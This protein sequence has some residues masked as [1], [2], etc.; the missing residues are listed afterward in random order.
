MDL[1]LALSPAQLS[2]L[3]GETAT[4]KVASLFE[5]RQVS[6]RLAQIRLAKAVKLL[7]KEDSSH[8]L[9][10]LLFSLSHLPSD[11]NK[12]RISIL[13]H[14]LIPLL[15]CNTLD[16]NTKAIHANE[17]NPS[18]IP[19]S[20]TEHLNDND[21]PLHAVSLNTPIP[22]FHWS[23]FPHIISALED[24]RPLANLNR[25]LHP[26]F[27]RSN[28]DETT[29]ASGTL[30]TW[31]LVDI[32]Q[33]AMDLHWMVVLGTWYLYTGQI[34]VWLRRVLN[35]MLERPLVGRSNA[36]YQTSTPVKQPSRRLTPTILDMETFL[37]S[38]IALNYTKC[39][40]SCGDKSLAQVLWT[41]VCRKAWTPTVKMAAFWNAMLRDYSDSMVDQVV[42][43]SIMSAG[44]VTKYLRDIRAVSTN[45]TT[46][47]A[48]PEN[49][50][51]VLAHVGTVYARLA[52]MGV[53]N[54]TAVAVAVLEHVV[55]LSE[56]RLGLVLHAETGG[57]FEDLADG[58]TLTDL[59]STLLSTC[60]SYHST[61]RA[62]LP[63]T[64]TT[65]PL[66]RFQTTPSKPTTTTFLPSPPRQ[67]F[68]TPSISR[69][70]TPS[71][72][73]SIA[74]K[75]FFTPAAVSTP[76]PKSTGASTTPGSR[77][78]WGTPGTRPLLRD[79]SF[80]RA[81]GDLDVAVVPSGEGEEEGLPPMIGLEEMG[82]MM[83]SVEML[84]DVRSPAKRRG[85]GAVIGG[86]K[87]GGVYALEG[88]RI[89]SGGG[90]FGS[91][92]GG[93]MDVPLPSRGEWKDLWEEE[94]VERED[95]WA[96]FGDGE[97]GGVGGE[98]VED[99]E[100]GD[101][102]GGGEVGRE[103]KG[104]LLQKIGYI[105]Y[106]F[107]PTPKSTTQPKSSAPGVSILR[108]LKGVDAN[109][110]DNLRSSFELNYP[111]FEIL[112]SVAE[113]TDPAVGVVRDLMAEFPGVEA[114][115]IVGE[116]NL[117]V[118]PKVNNLLTSYSL[119]K[120]EIIWILDSNIRVTR[121]TIGRAVDCL[122][123]NPRVG[124]VH[125]I[126]IGMS[127]HSFG[128]TVEQ[129]YL[130]T[131]H[132]KVYTMINKLQ[133]GSC[134]IGKSNLFRKKE[135]AHVGGLAY[136]GKFMSE[137]N[138]IGQ[139]I[140]SRGRCHAIPADVVYQQLGAGSIGEYFMRR[141]R[142]TRIRKFTVVLATVVEPFMECLVNGVLGAYGFWVVFG[143]SRG[144]FF[145]GHV[146][147]WF[148]VDTMFG[149]VVEKSMVVDN[150]PRYVLAW[151][152]REVT[153]L[154]VLIYACAG[155]RVEWRGR[156]FKLK[157]DG[158]VIQ[159]SMVADGEGSDAVVDSLGKVLGS[160]NISTSE[161]VL[162]VC[163]VFVAGV[164]F[165]GA[166]CAEAVKGLFGQRGMDAPSSYPTVGTR[167]RDDAVHLLIGEGRKVDL[168][169]TQPRRRSTETSS[170]AAAERATISPFP[171]HK[172]IDLDSTEATHERLKRPL[173][174]STASFISGCSFLTPPTTTQAWKAMFDKLA[175]KISEQHLHEGTKGF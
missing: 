44:D 167:Q 154:P 93:L 9:K 135:L 43:E 156:K 4:A 152:V 60:K 116:S 14:V 38:L 74:P 45:S 113:G 102:L 27:V 169:Q 125:H 5:S 103:R 124:L 57:F 117:G 13:T 28:Q 80:T 71:P 11:P 52:L 35:R 65:S 99:E 58:L 137:D 8:A 70:R 15:A 25:I 40:Q 122:I 19:R 68:F 127:P 104:R 105:R 48:V 3:E 173:W 96:G 12:A 78:K 51:T 91:G 165:L 110:A 83:V 50:K 85:S 157:S 140:W 106:T 100:G 158:T 155:S 7:Q 134:V 95:S 62:Q 144:W 132:A 148:L 79:D 37:L 31:K 53:E 161:K 94:G 121:D 56:S 66:P 130:N 166:M 75:S 82:E 23:T 54:C 111:N 18:M 33:E 150:F 136:F 171:F 115:L 20:P 39:I 61:L 55:S 172:V 120:H 141:A 90:V 76:A 21:L 133:L 59:D 26:F 81:V 138:I 84:G 16:F 17:S 143:V 77:R 72:T 109:L 32:E 101:W 119:A 107:K 92:G 63:T 118:N 146:C 147:Y 128:S 64:T 174:E 69:S 149:I 89:L 112:F 164:L 87:G 97:V 86:K 22:A 151:I 163:T 30:E 126:P 123:E 142:W 145:V 175:E 1:L 131:S 36:A 67:P 88:L 108:P 34:R 42:G 10:P 29:D 47:A 160:A 6:E 162:G 2:S 49:V 153:A 24:L 73:R 41:S 46:S 129:L 139:T 168:P 114:R 170:A 98:V 159:D